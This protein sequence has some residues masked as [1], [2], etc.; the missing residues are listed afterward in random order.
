[1]SVI[2][3]LYKMLDAITRS[4]SFVTLHD[5]LLCFALTIYIF[6]YFAAQSRGT[7]VDALIKLQLVAV[8]PT[9]WRKFILSM[10][11]EKILNGTRGFLIVIF[12]SKSCYISQ[13]LNYFASSPLTVVIA[14]L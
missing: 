3:N 2:Y 8:V 10:H 7:H 11:A 12:V 4:I 5:V 13:A 6:N 1:M 9:S 14:D